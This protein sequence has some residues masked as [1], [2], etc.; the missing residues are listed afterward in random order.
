MTE[1]NSLLVSELHTRAAHA[2]TAAAYSH[3]TGDYASARE[4]ARKALGDTMAA[5]QYTEKI[6]RT[7]PELGVV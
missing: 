4:L 3:S 5:V 1:N 2:H 6:A 7:A